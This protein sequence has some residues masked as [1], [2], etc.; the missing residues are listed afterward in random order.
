MDLYVLSHL[1]SFGTNLLKNFQE[2]TKIC[3][4]IFGMC[5]Q[6]FFIFHDVTG[7]GKEFPVE[8]GQQSE[9]VL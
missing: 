1:E 6:K 5:V 3:V 7:S 2:P 9:C 8:T 4:L